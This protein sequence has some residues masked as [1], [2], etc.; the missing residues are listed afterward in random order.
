MIA[1]MP[2]RKSL[3]PQQS[4]SSGRGIG[5]PS[6]VLDMPETAGTLNRHCGKI[7]GTTTAARPPPFV[8]VRSKS[9]FGNVRGGRIRVT[10]PV[11]QC[12]RPII[13]AGT[14][15]KKDPADKRLSSGTCGSRMPARSRSAATLKRM[16]AGKIHGARPTPLIHRQ[17]VGRSV[18]PCRPISVSSSAR[19][20]P[21]QT[22]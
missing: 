20:R 7:T 16:S 11:G 1:P 19:P 14:S 5:Q 13:P 22:K 2:S 3:Q 18:V 17:G 21:D 9:S 10:Q 6:F 15:D 12:D 4:G 8:Q